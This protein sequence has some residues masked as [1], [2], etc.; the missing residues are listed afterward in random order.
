MHDFCIPG[1]AQLTF[2]WR[3]AGREVFCFRQICVHISRHLQWASL[4]ACDS[5]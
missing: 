3:A 2:F 4:I 5:L 1:A